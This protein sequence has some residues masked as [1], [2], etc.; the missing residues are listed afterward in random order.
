MSDANVALYKRWFEEVWNQRRRETITELFAR[1]GVAHGVSDSGGDIHGPA[2]FLPFYDR[3]CAGFPDI[4]VVVEDCFAAGDKVVARYVAT[5]NH[6]GDYM[7]LRASGKK[8]TAMGLSVGR[9]RNGQIVESWDSWDKLALMQQIGGI[10]F[11][12]QSAGAG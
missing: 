11:T 9:V 4:R 2:E 6:T 10:Q 3:L 12:G 5:M 1:D 7:G 8:A